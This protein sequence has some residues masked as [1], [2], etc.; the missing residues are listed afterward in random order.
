MT[1]G[2]AIN[3]SWARPKT[4]ASV[5]AQ[6]SQLSAG[7]TTCIAFSFSEALFKELFDSHKN[8]LYKSP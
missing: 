2:F 4:I 6:T 1:D 5:F 7:A 8:V 3:K